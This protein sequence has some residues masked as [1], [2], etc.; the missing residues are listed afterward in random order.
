MGFS[1]TNLNGNDLYFSANCTTGGDSSSSQ[2]PCVRYQW[3]DSACTQLLTTSSYMDAGDCV[4]NS[5]C[6]FFATADSGSGWW[7][8]FGIV[9]VFAVV[10][11]VVAGVGGFLYWKKKQQSDY[12]VY[13]E[14]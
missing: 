11:V 7:W 10:A 5:P 9:A 1:C 12:S 13:Q 2:A 4:G 3:M 14:N 8:F 6:T